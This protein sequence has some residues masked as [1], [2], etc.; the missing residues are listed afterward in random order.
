MPGRP[1][2]SPPRKGGA[3]TP[4]RPGTPVDPAMM[5]KFKPGDAVRLLNDLEEY[6]CPVISRKM[7]LTVEDI[8]GF[9]AG[10]QWYRVRH[11][12][13]VFSEPEENLAPWERARA[14]DS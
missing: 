14:T 6:G 9:T 4:E 7:R 5:P 1:G 11:G 8:G 2:P 13:K 3:P 12:D 10:S